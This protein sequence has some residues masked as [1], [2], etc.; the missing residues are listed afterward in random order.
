MLS[1]IS[2]F[3]KNNP[4]FFIILAGLLWS[5]DT[6]FRHPISTVIKNDE[7]IVLMEHLIG[8]LF[9][10]P[11]ILVNHRDS[12]LKL[13]K[14]DW[15]K[16]LFLGSCGSFMANIFFTKSLGALGPGTFA[17]LQ[18]FQPLF[19]AYMAHQFL[20]E[21]FDGLY[22]LWAMWVIGSSI[23]IN[24]VDF[25]IGNAFANMTENPLETLMALASMLIWGT[26]TVVGKNLLT[27]YSPV[28][29]VF[30]RWFFAFLFLSS[31][32]ALRGSQI[33]ISKFLQSDVLWRIISMGTI[34]GALAMAI[35]YQGLKKF[36]AGLTAFFE[37]SYPVFSML[38]ASFYMYEKIT[39]IQLIGIVSI[40]GAL[41]FMLKGSNLFK[42]NKL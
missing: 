39:F 7:S 21:E 35:Y 17:F 23:L 8:L 34:L 40:T 16:V 13:T 24:M 26:C 2:I 36:P 11:F 37:L 22:P 14:G 18:S 9:T 1:R 42:K 25:E 10:L 12:F 15:L 32:F 38:L 28:V 33:E 20:K 19:V 29:I 30:W 5:L 4:V 6:L 41:F 31:H 3:F 27:K